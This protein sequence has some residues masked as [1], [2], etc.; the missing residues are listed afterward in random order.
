LQI[1]TPVL[2]A[3]GLFQELACLIHVVEIN[4]PLEAALQGQEELPIFI[5]TELTYPDKF[6][7]CVGNLDLGNVS[8]LVAEYVQLT[9]HW[10]V[11]FS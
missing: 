6:V 11:W 5:S 10:L 9:R 7:K 1:K 8:V 4:F 3:L 2:V